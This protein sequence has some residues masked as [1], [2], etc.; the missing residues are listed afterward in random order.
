MGISFLGDVL[1]A[2]L[3]GVPG[4]GRAW[5][6]QEHGRQQNLALREQQL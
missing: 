3:I 1:F 5:M 2:L 6:P 4:S